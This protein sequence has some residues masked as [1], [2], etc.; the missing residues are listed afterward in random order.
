MNLELFADRWFL[1]LYPALGLLLLTAGLTVWLR[2]E[3]LAG[4]ILDCAGLER[5]PALWVQSLRSLALLGVVSLGLSVASPGWIDSLFSAW[6]LFLILILGR[7]LAVWEHT[8]K[9]LRDAGRLYALLG[10]AALQL[11]VLGLVLFMMLLEH[12]A[13]R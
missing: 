8:R 1:T 2:R 11:A 6:I 13:G 7:M 4:H 9:G 5:P 3:A 10:R 12:R